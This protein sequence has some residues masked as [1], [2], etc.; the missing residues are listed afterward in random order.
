MEDKIYQGR[1]CDEMIS[2]EGKVVLIEVYVL[3]MQH[4]L[5]KLEC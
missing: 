3:V 4:Y 2:K 1:S 5:S